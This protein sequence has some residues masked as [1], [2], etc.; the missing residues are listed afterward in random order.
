MTENFKNLK[1]AWKQ[2]IKRKQIS[3]SFGNNKFSNPNWEEKID[4]SNSFEELD[5]FGRKL[6]KEIGDG[7]S[8]L[9]PL[10]SKLLN[11]EEKILLEVTAKDLK[12]LQKQ[13]TDLEI[14]EDTF[15]NLTKNYELGLKGIIGDDLTNW[16]SKIIKAGINDKDI[17]D[18]QKKV[19]D[20]TTNLTSV[21]VEKDKTDKELKEKQQQ[22]LNH[23]CDTPNNEELNQTKR[24]LVKA[25]QEI[26]SLK[27]QLDKNPD[28]PL[29]NSPNNNDDDNDKTLPEKAINDK[30]ERE[31]IQEDNNLNIEQLKVKLNEK[32]QE[33]K[34]LKIK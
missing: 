33:I 2:V 23:H 12:E 19:K 24:E 16:E 5:E 4:K 8:Y 31:E 13:L 21:Q 1:E 27:E 34:S 17:T 20:L 25:N 22:I 11:D 32:R 26:T 14:D 15:K 7:S 9:L 6:R 28:N 29:P 10:S 18:L 3:Q 30:E